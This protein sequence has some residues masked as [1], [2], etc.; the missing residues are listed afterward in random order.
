LLTG[1]VLQVLRSIRNLMEME[2][3]DG[4]MAGENKPRATLRRSNS[5]RDL[6]KQVH[7]Q[8]S[9]A[10]ENLS[11]PVGTEI[12]GCL[13]QRVSAFMVHL[14]ILLSLIFLRPLLA[15][16]PMSVLRGLFLY[17]GWANLNGNEFWERI[18]L[19]ITDPT[20][21]PKR[22]Y[23]KVR[24]L[25]KVHVWTLIQL[26]LLILVNI[27]MVSPAGFIFPVVI[28]LLHPIRLSLARSGLYTPEELE[29]LDSHF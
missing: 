18:W 1:A 27:L 17:C 20:K 3:M 4:V 24:P 22:T 11:L 15:S 8:A 9:S 16:I 29:F 23:V 7:Q 19:V 6:L 28:G 14:L 25:W 13:E 21:Y 10:I 26:I 5:D 2:P 12:T